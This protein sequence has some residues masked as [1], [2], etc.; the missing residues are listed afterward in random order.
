MTTPPPAR[1]LTEDSLAHLARRLR[2]LGH[3]VELAPRARL[4][5]LLA[6]AAADGRVVLTRSTRRPRRWR[7]VQ[8][9]T[10]SGELA[11]DVRRI[12]EAFPAAGAPFT[13]CTACNGT[14]AMRSAFEA[15]GE[16]PA[17][18]LRSPG[19]LRACTRCARWF[20]DGS[21]VSRLRAWLESA[22]GRPLPGDPPV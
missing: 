20:W 11:A 12:D 14:L 16:V 8:T 22:L 1:F 2:V 7:D 3:D 5:E 21:H 10:V 19:R 6:A 17:R 18:V 15:R 9:V 4:D 13:R